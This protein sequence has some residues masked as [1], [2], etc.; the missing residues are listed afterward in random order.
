MTWTKVTS[1]EDLKKAGRIA[2]S[3]S[4]QNILIMWHQN[5]AHAIENSC[6]HLK[7]PLTEG[8]LE[9]CVLTCPF[10]GASF[11]IETG[12]T[13][14]PPAVSPIRVIEC[15]INNENIELDL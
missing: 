8:V 4:Q 3:H 1:L 11:S 9:N 12:Q 7:K 13:L 5:G 14:S 15:R 10:H 2:L 6:S